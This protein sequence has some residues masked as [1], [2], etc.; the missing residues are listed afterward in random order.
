LGV[1]S[2]SLQNVLLGHNQRLSFRVEKCFNDALFLPKSGKIVHKLKHFIG[3]EE[4]TDESSWKGT[5]NHKR[6]KTIA[7]DYTKLSPAF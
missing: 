7:V 2:E 1:I 5:T 6:L 4:D 3:E